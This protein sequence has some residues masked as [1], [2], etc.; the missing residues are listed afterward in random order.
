M[1]SRRV[2]VV[3]GAAAGIGRATV[4]HLVR[5][6]ATDV[7]AVD[8]DQAGLRHLAE[9]MAEPERLSVEPVDVSSRADLRAL[10]GRVRDAHGSISG[11]VCAAGLQRYGTV[12][13]TSDEVFDEIIGVNVGGVFFA[14][15]ELIPLIKGG[16]SVVVVSS[17]QA[18]G[19]QNQVAA[20]AMGKGALLSLVKAM[21]VDHADAGVRVNAVCPGSVDTPML[22]H[23]AELF[24][25]GRSSDDVIA[26]WGS[27]HPIGRV[28]QAAEVAEAIAFL[29]DQRSSF[30]T[31]TELRVD[32]GLTAKLPV[33]IP[34]GT[35]PE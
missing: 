26:E 28:A 35:A 24:G 25:G 22:R 8:R 34:G 31:G 9:A 17:V 6:P 32:G 15:R 27:V 3:T 1:D 2:I 4:E 7:V 11:L 19:A 10:A 33:A 14:C 30:I 20:Y 21:A 13:E 16:G 29:L 12:T 18:F 23:S 5:G